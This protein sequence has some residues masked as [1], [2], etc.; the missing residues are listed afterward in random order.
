MGTAR[1]LDPERVRS[2]EDETINR[3]RAVAQ[4]RHPI[5]AF[6]RRTIPV[7]LESWYRSPSGEPGWTVSYV[8]SVRQYPPGPED[9][10]C[11][12]ETLVSGWIH[13]RDGQLM[14]VHQLRGK[15]TYCDRVG[16]TYMLPFGRVT[17]REDSYWVFQLS[18]WEA[19]SYEVV[20]VRPKSVRYVLEVFGGAGRRCR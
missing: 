15:L 2:V 18:G 1:G 16:A 7:R 12:L 8:E 9:K 4:W 3:V 13:H 6:K 19:E 20:A 14:D 11:G 5:P 10:G 17:P